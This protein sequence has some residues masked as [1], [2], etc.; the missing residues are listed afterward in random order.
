MG[1]LYS[2]LV[3]ALKTSRET[4]NVAA[5][6]TMDFAEQLAVMRNKAAVALEPLGT[7]L[8][9]AVNSA[10][11]AIEGLIGKLS[12]LVDWFA[13]LSGGSQKLILSFIGIAAAIGPLL[14]LVGILANGIWLTPRTWPRS[15]PMP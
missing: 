9:Q 15:R 1:P 14:T 6:E 8:M 13:N 5:F 11:P 2:E 10:M 7:S 12:G 3:S 4:I